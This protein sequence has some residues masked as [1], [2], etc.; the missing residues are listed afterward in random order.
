VRVT[1]Q[2][3]TPVVC[4][5]KPLASGGEGQVYLASNGTHVIKLYSNAQNWRGRQ[6]VGQIIDKGKSICNDAAW[7]TLFC[8]PDAVVTAPCLGVRMPCAD[9]NLL[10]LSYFL[11][12]ETLKLIRSGKHPIVKPE[13][14]GTWAEVRLPTEAEWE[15]TARGTDGRKFLWGDHWDGNKCANSEGSN[16]LSSTKPVGSYPQGA[17][18]YG[19]HDTAGNVWEWCADWFGD[20]YYASSLSENPTGPGSGQM[21]V[22]RGGSWYC[23]FEFYF[24]CSSRSRGCPNGGGGGFRCLQGSS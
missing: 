20:K 24:R 2:D 18:P 23:D 14:M 1:L 17:S 15:K 16:S 8:W 6:T 13:F 5:D 10:K 7:Q 22:L 19:C 21:R 4:H 12:P 3:G 9:R 11:S